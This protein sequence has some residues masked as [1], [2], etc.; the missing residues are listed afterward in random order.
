MMLGALA[1]IFLDWHQR[2]NEAPRASRLAM[3][4]SQT[5]PNMELWIKIFA[6]WALAI[7][8]QPGAQ[9]TLFEHLLRH[10]LPHGLN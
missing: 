1:R 4:Y 10:G 7:F 2:M 3:V 9:G 5:I 6:G 8:E